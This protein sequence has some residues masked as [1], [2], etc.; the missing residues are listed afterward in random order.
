MIA[1]AENILGAFDDYC[2]EFTGFEGKIDRC[3][4]DFG[5]DLANR[6][7]I[8]AS[9]PPSRGEKARQPGR[10]LFIAHLGSRNGQGEFGWG[11]SPPFISAIVLNRRR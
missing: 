5:A 6:G 7:P 2:G 11:R 4:T 3:A 10:R 8:E 9:P 1:Y